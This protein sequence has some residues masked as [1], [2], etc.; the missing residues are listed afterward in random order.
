MIIT[1][2]YLA[3]NFAMLAGVH[4]TDVEEEESGTHLH[5]AYQRVGQI[6]QNIMIHWMCSQLQSSHSVCPYKYC[7]HP[8][9]E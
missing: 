5:A 7:W 9:L 1:E 8:L 3:E 6:L 2:Q 4:C